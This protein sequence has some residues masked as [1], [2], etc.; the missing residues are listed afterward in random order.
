MIGALIGYV[1]SLGVRV[2]PPA[3]R[4]NV[5]MNVPTINNIELDARVLLRG[6]PVG[7]VTGLDATP[8]SATIAFYVDDKYKIPV[9]SEVRLENL[10][11]LGE[12]YIEFEPR[13]S[14]GPY[15]QDGQRIAAESV[16]KPHSISELGASVTRVLNEMNPDELSQIVGEADQGLPDPNAVLPNLANASL[17]LRN[18]AADMHGQGREVLRNL[19]TLLQN[20]GWVGPA[21]ADAAPSLG[22]IGRGIHATANNSVHIGV[23]GEQP[24][25]TY[26]F[27]K[28]LQRLQKLLDDRGP[29]IRVVTEPLL[30]NVKAIAGALRSVDTSQ[31]LTNLLASVPEDGSI[32]LHVASNGR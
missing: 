14:G 5:S 21:L 16:K 29:D 26:V 11:A 13:H 15:L 18:T 32:E 12:S 9:D 27:G 23:E 2:A 8:A 1:A 24:T 6:V 4:T 20:A 28:L 10:S 3:N 30:A 19:E 25:V 17:L 22:Q 31:I 7:K